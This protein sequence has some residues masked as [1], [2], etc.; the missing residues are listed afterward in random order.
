MTHVTI[1]QHTAADG[2][3]SILTTL[4]DL[5][6][7]TTVI[8]VDRGDTIPESIPS[9]ILMTFG[10]P[11]SLMD[12]TV[13][14][15][16]HQEQ[17]LLRSAL[18]QDKAVLGI[19]FGAQL[20]AS[21]LGGLVTV[22]R[23]AEVGWHPV[24]K[25]STGDQPDSFSMLPSSFHA[26]HWHRNTFEIPKG[27]AHLYRSEACVHQAF[28]F[29]RKVVGF[30]FHFEANEKT[31]RRFLLAS[32]LWKLESP[33]VQGREEILEETEVFLQGQQMHLANFIGEFVSRAGD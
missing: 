15:W 22:N 28:Q 17:R 10:A 8:R 9:D 18:D 19:C 4:H 16:V 23:E 21:V 12:G 24:W 20:L 5:S 14:S 33:S 7:A 31:V 1:I 30:Q 25:C 32:K 11:I 3:G 2:P 6:L 27:C 29:G 26:F 13:P